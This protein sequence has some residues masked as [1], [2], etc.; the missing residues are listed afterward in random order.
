MNRIRWAA[1]CSWI[2]GLGF[3][4]PCAY[5]IWYYADRGIVWQFLGFPTY[6][7]GPFEQMGLPTSVPLLTG[8]L[9]VCIGEVVVGWKL[10]RG[11]RSGTVLGLAL[12]PIET[13]FWIGF[14]L[15]LGPPLGVA[16]TVL[17]VRVRAR[18]VVA[19]S[20]YVA[21]ANPGEPRRPT[22]LE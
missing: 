16:R 5:G 13:V 22:D 19:T 8:F 10:G 18:R 12:L 3:G 4:L 1:A 9:L 21:S 20:P 6:G 17:C 11:E 7:H 15:P 2:L 14:A